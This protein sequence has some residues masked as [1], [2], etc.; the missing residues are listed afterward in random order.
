MAKDGY[1]KIRRLVQRGEKLHAEISEAAIS[2]DRA[3]LWQEVSEASVL[4]AVWTTSLSVGTLLSLKNFPPWIIWI[5]FPPSLPP[6]LPSL[7]LFWGAKM[8]AAI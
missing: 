3:R 8:S 5:S 2:W 1:H 6:F 4:Q 7:S